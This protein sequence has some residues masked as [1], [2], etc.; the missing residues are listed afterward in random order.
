MPEEEYP[1]EGVRLCQP[2]VRLP[3]ADGQAD[4]FDD[5]THGSSGF[6]F[7][8]DSLYVMIKPDQDRRRKPD[9]LTLRHMEEDLL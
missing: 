1:G 4:T 7:L 8:I 6:P 5:F 2:E 9:A 3:A